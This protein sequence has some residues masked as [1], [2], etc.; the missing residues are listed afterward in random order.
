M[1]EN[2]FVILTH[3]SSTTVSLETYI[4]LK[5]F[6]QVDARFDMVLKSTAD[7]YL[8]NE[9]IRN[10]VVWTRVS[11]RTKILKVACGPLSNFKR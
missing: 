8:F 11:D 9:N 5:I 3:R 1:V 4:L 2:C 6:G 10:N 7:T